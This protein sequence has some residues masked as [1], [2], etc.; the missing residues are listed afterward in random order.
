MKLNYVSVSK[1]YDVKNKKDKYIIRGELD[2]VPSLLWFKQLQ[3][4]WIC[5]PKLRKVCIEPQL[6]KNTIII[7]LLNQDNL[8][9]VIDIL[10][11][12]IDRV[13]SSYILQDN[14]AFSCTFKESIL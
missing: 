11:S 4:L 2:S 1:G 3:L 9:E 12:L 10:K 7:S 13:N 6:N 8:L 5:S 14:Q